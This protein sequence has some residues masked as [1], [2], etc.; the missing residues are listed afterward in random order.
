MNKINTALLI[1]MI[2]SGAKKIS[3]NFEYIND[4]NVFPVPDGDT[5]TNMKISI[6][7]AYEAIKKYD[8]KDLY[9]F[10]RLFCRQLLLNARGNSGVIFSQIIR[11][12]FE[13]VKEGQEEID[14]K[15]FPNYLLNAKNKSY[16]SVT[17]PV[18]GTILTVVRVLS[19]KIPNEI[20][21]LKTLTDLFKYL[22]EETKNI[23]EDTPNLLPSLKEAGVVDSGAYGL[24]CF[25]EGMLEGIDGSY[26]S[27]ISSDQKIQ[28]TILLKSKKISYIDNLERQA[29]SE[30]GFGYCSEFI[31]KLDYKLFPEQNKKQPFD[32]DKIEADLLKIGDSLVLVVD[33][34]IVKVHMHTYYPNLLLHIGLAYGEFLKI[35]IENMTEQFLEKYSDKSPEEIFKKFKLTNKIQVICTV[36]SAKI[37]KFFKSEFL[38]N[39]FIN[40]SI[41]GNPSIT[42]FNNKINEVRSKNIIIIID[43]SNIF[44]SAEQ[45]VKLN[46]SKFNIVLIKAS[47]IIESMVAL[48][49]FD[50]KQDLRTNMK[51]LEKAIKYSKSLLVSTSTKTLKT[52]AG[53]NVNKDDYIGIIDKEIRT[54]SD[55]LITATNDA[56]KLLVGRSKPPII[57]L[58]YGSETNDNQ[59]S[60]VQKYINEKIGAKCK[61]IDGK[62]KVYQFYIGY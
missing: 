9:G 51:A 12:F 45:A 39:T 57:Y 52:K 1:K 49:S 16:S 24:L 17:S 32:K 54:S 23:V 41:T 40:T 30:E 35:K 60:K 62:Q 5:G 8:S 15:D 10:S 47:N 31:C 4:L 53:L 13:D 7:G 25:F 29:I 56:I 36:P 59:V 22:V 3:D 37:G 6:M 34:D 58:M 11:G 46:N 48:M 19:E 18:E 42:D 21:K 14:V 27:T 55:D 26:V 28:K 20:N 43:D 44:L 61:L 50:E 38:I 2:E 33:E